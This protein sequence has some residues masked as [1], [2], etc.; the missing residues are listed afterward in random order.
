MA[1][2]R[3]DNDINCT[4]EGEGRRTSGTPGSSDRTPGTRT[5]DESRQL[6]ASTV[7]RSARSSVAIVSSRIVTS[8]YC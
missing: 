4:V 5:N 6:F 2:R 1:N 8:L 3:S 7:A